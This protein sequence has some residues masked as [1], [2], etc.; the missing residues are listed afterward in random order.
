MLRQRHFLGLRLGLGL[1][2]G[3]GLVRVRVRVSFSFRSSFWVLPKHRVVI[4][5]TLILLPLGILALFIT[6]SYSKKKKVKLHLTFHTV[7]CE[8]INSV[9]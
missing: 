1:E 4:G 9:F 8:G 2:L 3:L 7:E 5:L 6:G